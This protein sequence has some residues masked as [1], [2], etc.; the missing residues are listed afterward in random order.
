MFRKILLG[1]D[2]YPTNLGI[3][4]CAASLKDTGAEEVVLAHIII[5]DAPGLEKMLVTQ[6]GP[7]M[8]RQ[9]SI[10]GWSART[11]CASP[12]RDMSGD[13][14]AAAVLRR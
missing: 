5:S 14:T 7:E 8:E 4:S 2:L 13:G 3:L 9:R 12:V 6:A 1:V 11:T 10:C